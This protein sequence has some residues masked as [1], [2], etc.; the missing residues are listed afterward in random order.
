ME[1]LDSSAPLVRLELLA[2]LPKEN[3]LPV[4]VDRAEE[5]E[6][7]DFPIVSPYFRILLLSTLSES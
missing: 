4:E 6:A 5:I 1:G 2:G 3:M 7:S